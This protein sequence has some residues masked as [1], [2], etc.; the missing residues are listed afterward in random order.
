MKKFALTL[1]LVL[2][3]LT[4]QA[5]E[6][7]WETDINKAM[8]ISKKSK[9]PLMLFFTGSDWCGWCIRLQKEVLKTP[10]FAKWANKNVVLVELDFPRR[11]PQQPELQ[12]Q[13]QELQQIFGIQGF[14]TVWFAKASKKDGKIN[15]EQL[16]STGY[17][18]G[19]PA[20]WLSGADQI[21]AKD[22]KS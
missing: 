2:G 7:K 22:K 11:S 14:P 4:I 20:A 18:A 15:F 10:E 16:G 19:G 3:S 6:L 17:V 1:F 9:K 5:Q 21:L 12:K 13:N 8:E